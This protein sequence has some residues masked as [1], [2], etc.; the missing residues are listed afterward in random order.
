[1]YW[2]QMT[3]S[4]QYYGINENTQNNKVRE[5]ADNHFPL[6]QTQNHALR[7][8]I[9]HRCGGLNLINVGSTE[10]SSASTLNWGNQ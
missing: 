2:K 1:M 5:T 10:E 3:F 7:N 8:I 9:F 4:S 6:R